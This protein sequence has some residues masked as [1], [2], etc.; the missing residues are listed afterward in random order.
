MKQA[1][2]CRIVMD[3]QSPNAAAT[4]SAGGRSRVRDLPDAMMAHVVLRAHDMHTEQE[5]LRSNLWHA[6][7]WVT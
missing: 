7:T 2:S 4:T 5:F 1:F 6:S 3:R